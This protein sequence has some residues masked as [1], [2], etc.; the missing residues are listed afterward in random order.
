MGK[1]KDAVL[2]TVSGPDHPGITNR[3]MEVVDK[4]ETTLLDMGQS[5][6][7]GLLSL[8]FLLDMGASEQRKS[9]VLK[10]LLFEAKEL[11]LSL[12]FE[13]V[14][15]TSA[16]MD[17]N[18]ERF[19]LNC[20]ST[21]KLTAKFI[22]EVA[23][24][25]AENQVNIHRIDTVS[26]YNFHS[27]EILTTVPSGLEYKDLKSKLLGVS[28][29]HQVDVAFLKDNVWRRNKRLIVFDMDSTLIQTE[30]IDEIAIL[31][32]AGDKVKET[33]ERAMNGEIDFDQSLLERVQHLKGVKQDQLYEIVE[34]LPITPGAA[35]F[36]SR[37]RSLGYKTAIISGG[38]TIFAH[39]LKEKLGLDF[40]F[41]NELEIK[42]GELTGN[43]VGSIV[44]ANQNK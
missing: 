32:G 34:R 20:V 30:V 25:L 33:T 19:I 23:E 40:A 27:L 41:A 28:S 1:N 5:V 3:L 7:H 11:G 14:N 44:N 4:N 42:N 39:A 16:Q 12:D 15:S 13:L 36:I 31:A 17:P 24:V 22:R 35:E 37:V 10:D 43:I 6:T 29:D 18:D 2:V 38:F 8:S 26:P 21:E 9:P